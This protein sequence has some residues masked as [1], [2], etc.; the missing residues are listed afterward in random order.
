MKRKQG[1]VLIW[2]GVALILASLC[3]TGYNIYDANRAKESSE[4]ILEQLIPMVPTQPPVEQTPAVTEPPVHPDEVEIPDYLLNPK[5][6]MPEQ[7]VDGKDYIGILEI[8]SLELKLPVIGDWSMDNVRLAPC[9]Y[10]GTAY[11][12]NLIIAAHNYNG[13]FGRVKELQV[14]E[15]VR[16]TDMDGN[17]FLYQVVERETLMPTAIRQMSAGEWDLTLFTCTVGGAYR[18]T[19]RCELIVENGQYPNQELFQ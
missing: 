19:I 10:E 13:H 2:I 9:R 8:P 4:Q 16:F 3:L 18:L 15:Q 12:K 14:G 1:T 6:D 7:E 17:L 5:M 11:L